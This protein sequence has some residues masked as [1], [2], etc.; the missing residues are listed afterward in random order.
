MKKL[1][2][3]AA[4]LALGSF[5]L[6]QDAPASEDSCV[7][8]VESP[9]ECETGRVSHEGSNDGVSAVYCNM[10]PEEEGEDM[11]MD[12]KTQP[13][14]FYTH[15]VLEVL[16][17]QADEASTGDSDSAMPADDAADDDDM[18]TSSEEDA[19]EEDSNEDDTAN[20]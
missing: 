4:V 8:V 16:L 9:D 10:C 17:A 18:E 20:S 15:D 11:G 7:V 12:S 13:Q 5:A 1:I 6:A 14:A 19:G 3:A 2:M